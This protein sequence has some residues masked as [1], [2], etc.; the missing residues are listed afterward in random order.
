MPILNVK[1]NLTPAYNAAVQ[2]LVVISETTE[3]LSINIQN[4]THTYT[5]PFQQVGTL[6]YFAVPRLEAAIRITYTYDPAT[7][8]LDLYGND[9]VAPGQS[10]CL[11]TRPESSNQICQQHTYKGNTSTCGNK[12]WNCSPQY[13]PDLP[14]VLTSSIRATNESI[15]TAAKAQFSTV[16]IKTP[17]PALDTIEESHKWM[18]MHDKDGS[19]LGTFDP[20]REYPEG[21]TMTN[22]LES[23]WGGE[24]YFNQD[25]HIANVIGSSPDPKISH[26]SWI[27][28]WE[29][30]FGLEDQCTS[31]NWASGGAFVCNGNVQAN[32][33]GGHVIQGTVAS[34]IPAGSNNV[35]IIPICKN[36]NNND[37]VYMRANV[38]TQAIWLNNYLT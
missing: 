14:A 33:V 36:H 3:K 25:Q 6:K 30:Q 9:F 34:A 21:T 16:R 12:N 5:S 32:R 18:T 11:L 7:G 31:H 24:V 13:T 29:R 37:N 8:V 28:L 2:Q 23:T 26:K 27:E 35:Y 17:P 20:N 10:T 19:F 4:G 38:Y 22:H 1:I 15:I